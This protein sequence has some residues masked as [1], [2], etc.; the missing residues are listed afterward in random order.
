[1]G[2]GEVPKLVKEGNHLEETAAVRGLSLKNMLLQKRSINEDIKENRKKHAGKVQTRQ[3][4]KPCCYISGGTLY[5]N[6]KEDIKESRQKHA[7][8]VQTRQEDKP[9]NGKEDIKESRQ[10]RAEK[11][12][13]GQK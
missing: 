2:D 8:K 1:M 3:E 11:A 5:C 6:C 4:D 9:G 10:K 7:G 12:Q 13:T